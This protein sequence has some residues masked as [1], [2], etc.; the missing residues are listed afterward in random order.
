VSSDIFALILYFPFL[1]VAVMGYHRYGGRLALVRLNPF[2]SRL[3]M[4]H[5]SLTLVVYII[6]ALGIASHFPDSP[7][8]AVR[9]CGQG[10][11][12]FD[13][14]LL[15]SCRTYF[16][17]SFAKWFPVTCIFFGVIGLAVL[18]QRMKGRPSSRR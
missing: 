14:Q 2:F 7:D 12:N 16:H 15:S 13:T 18:L 11:T 9:G 10:M 5:L 3:L 8:M 4:W 1:Y 17:D 6:Y